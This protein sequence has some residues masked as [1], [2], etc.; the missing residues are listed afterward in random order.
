MASPSAIIASRSAMSGLPAS[1]LHAVYGAGAVTYIRSAPGRKTKPPPP[2]AV[3]ESWRKEKSLIPPIIAGAATPG[4]AAAE[5]PQNRN[6][7]GVPLH[8]RH[9]RRVLRCSTPRWQT[10]TTTALG[11]S[12]TG[13][14][15]E[16]EFLGRY[17]T[18][19]NR[20]VSD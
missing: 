19:N 1:R 16:A 20:S 6:R 14:I 4:P 8:C 5:V 15:R 17:T 2:P 11:T 7:E 12:G 9:S 18:A 13:R 10:A 3:T